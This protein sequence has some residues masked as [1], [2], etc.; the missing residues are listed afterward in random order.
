MTVHDSV[1]K[2]ADIDTANCQYGTRRRIER[3]SLGWQ[4][5]EIAAE[6]GLTLKPWQRYVVDVALELDEHT[7]ELAYDTVQISVGRRA[8]KTLLVFLLAVRRM[9]EQR[10]QLVWFTAQDERSAATHFRNEYVP[11]AE[12]WGDKFKKR[13]A[14]GSESLTLLSNG[15][16]FSLFSPRPASLHGYNSDMV[17]IDECWAFGLE[18]GE[19]LEVG[20]RPTTWTRPGAQVLLTSAAGDSSSTWWA[21]LLDAGRAAVFEDLG[22]G[23][24]HF[25]WTPDGTDLD[26]DDPLTWPLVHPG[27]LPEKVMLAEY[28]RDRDQF[29]RTMLNV[30]DRSK[31]HGSPV[32]VT[33]WRNLGTDHMATRTGTITLGVDVSPDQATAA[34][35]ASLEGGATLELID[36]RPGTFWVADRL[37]GLFDAY[38]VHTIALDPGGPAGALVPALQAQALPLSLL[39][40]RD[41]T[42][43]SAGLVQA[44]RT[45]T[46]RHRV[47]ASLDAA[48]DGAR[49]RSVGDGAWTFSR[50]KS[51]ADVA[52]IVAASFAL[53]AHPDTHTHAP[54]SID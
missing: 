15:S 11:L 23:I 50:T 14:N 7:G 18:R 9:R 21:A 39:A 35:V 49:K 20:V 38:D 29:V 17:I 36:H 51:L 5:E 47:D 34:I 2:G 37:V 10:N 3:D 19:D 30:T 43:A 54:P 44:V 52:P 26:V 27:G 25:E 8:G 1:V 53:W 32:D 6:F 46:I 48:I 28:R 4:V 42:A 33:L 12:S 24:A 41:V 13:L 40:L 31:G 16:K 45:A 22:S